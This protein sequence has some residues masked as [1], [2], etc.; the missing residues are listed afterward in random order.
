LGTPA[1]FGS[2]Q[3]FWAAVVNPILL[4]QAS[5]A[6]IADCELDR[7]NESAVLRYFQDKYCRPALMTMNLGSLVAY[8]ELPLE[9]SSNGSDT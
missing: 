9:N 1:R 2:R 3:D 5:E 6:Y 7:N 4:E 8:V